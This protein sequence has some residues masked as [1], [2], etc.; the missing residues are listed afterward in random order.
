MNHGITSV[1]IKNVKVYQVE[2]SI[3]RR[4]YKKTFPYTEEGHQEAKEYVQKMHDLKYNS[5][6]FS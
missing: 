3:L 5:S 2:T 4:I 1:I 6:R